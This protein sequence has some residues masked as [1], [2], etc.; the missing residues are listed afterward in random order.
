VIQ[1]SFECKQ[2]DIRL[3]TN[4]I[5]ATLAHSSRCSQGFFVDYAVFFLASGLT[6][7]KRLV[8]IQIYVPLLGAELFLSR[9]HNKVT[10]NGATSS[11]FMNVC[12]GEV[13]NRRSRPKLHS[14]ESEYPAGGYRT[15][16][17]AAHGRILKTP[18]TQ[19]KRSV[20]LD[21]RDR[22][23]SGEAGFLVLGQVLPNQLEV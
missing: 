1:L 4:E 2:S 15:N 19:A 10:R 5:F 23:Y 12:H 9:L 11:H 7:E 18:S 6:L 14:K 3:Y 22:F 13:M 17:Q 20:V 21:T 8:C 16:P